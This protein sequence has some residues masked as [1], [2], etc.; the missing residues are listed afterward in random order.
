V[1]CVKADRLAARAY[2]RLSDEQRRAVDELRWGGPG[3]ARRARLKLALGWK[4][5]REEASALAREL[6]AEGL[7]R[8]AI[9]GCLKVSDRHLRRL[10][11]EPAETR[12]A[13]PENRPVTAVPM[14][15]LADTSCGPRGIAHPARPTPPAA[16]FRSLVE[17]DRWLEEAQP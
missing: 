17:L 2:R 8:N 6:Q 15:P 13:S 1:D 4:R 10:L 5:T 16:G 3:P 12:L 7:N 9:A 11:A 14:R